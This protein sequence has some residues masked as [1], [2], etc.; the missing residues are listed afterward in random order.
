MNFKR[1]K[2]FYKINVNL[3]F[4]W[5]KWIHRELFESSLI[6]I[7]EIATDFNNLNKYEKKILIFKNFKILSNF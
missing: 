2:K 7:Q 5:F 3:M 1:F 6:L 4:K